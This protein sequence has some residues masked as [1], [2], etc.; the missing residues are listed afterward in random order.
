MHQTIVTLSADVQPR[1][2]DA[3]RA[4]ITDLKNAVENNR[5][6]ADG[7][8][9]YEALGAAIPA[10][11]FASVMV[12]EDDHYDPLLTVELN[13]D[14]DITTFFPQLETS[15]LQDYLRAMV[16]CCK[17]PTGRAG[18]LYD[19]VTAPGSKIP[20]APF[21][22]TCIV[23]P[24]ASHQGNRGLDRVRIANE[25]ALF[26]AV[27]T[28][29]E[30]P[31]LYQAIDAVS[32]H[33]DLRADLLA[34]FPWLA[35]PSVARWTPRERAGDMARFL[36]FVA[37]VL[38]C[39]SIPGMV[40][41]LLIPHWIV[42]VL[43][44]IV[45]AFLFWKIWPAL[46]D[47]VAKR[48]TVEPVPGLPY[49][50]PR[51]PESWITIGAQ[52]VLF[53]AFY[54]VALAVSFTLLLAAFNRPDIALLLRQS[55]SVSLVGLLSVAMP[56]GFALVWVRWLEDRD[57][58]QDD[59]H[60]GDID[61]MRKILAQED[62]IAQNHMGSVVLVKPGLMRAVVIRAGLWGLGLGLRALMTSGYLGSMRTIHFAHWALLN[63][64]SRLVFFSNFDSS[65]ESYLDDFI[66]K[67]HQGLTLAWSNGVGF[68]PTELLIGK[69]ATNGRL[70]KA[71]ARHS[72]AEGLFW[73][74][75]YKDLSVNQIERQYEIAKGLCQPSL[76]PEDAS[77]WACNL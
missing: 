65:W 48:G 7:A 76:S 73:F 60:D 51:T 36:A 69:G 54:V 39:L 5:A 30:V 61:R 14:G 9:G 6:L 31:K 63:N 56:L 21:L 1:S 41:A 49:V 10:L 46:K 38:F 3:L 8:N 40:L 20:L 27:Q 75:A 23:K 2:L 66:E 58:W 29:L 68:P 67:A 28:K 59:P 50:A 11:H 64:G 72:M 35:A 37:L 17:R 4:R 57:S 53:L 43:C 74:S 70:F 26:S 22:E 16:R 77:L 42:V 18:V 12:F 33:R 62:Q 13:I 71:W 24:A 25:A 44:A 34:D 32:L 52:V 19:G 47:A 15:G 55:L 45:A